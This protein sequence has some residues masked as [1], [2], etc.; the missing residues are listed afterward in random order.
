[1]KNNNLIIDSNLK[2]YIESVSIK[3]NRDRYTISDGIPGLLLVLAQFYVTEKNIKSKEGI[4]SLAWDYINQAAQQNISLS[5]SN[6]GLWTGPLGL[7]VAA[8]TWSRIAD[9]SM[10]DWNLI[11]RLYYQSMVFLIKKWSQISRGDLENKFKRDIIFGFPGVLNYICNCSI[12]RK[13]EENNP[14]FIQTLKRIST[15]SLLQFYVKSSSSI[16]PTNLGM[17]HGLSGLLIAILQYYFTFKSLPKNVMQSLI[18]DSDYIANYANYLLSF[19]DNANYLFINN[20]CTGIPGLLNLMKITNHKRVFSKLSNYID[21]ESKSITS[22][23][24]MCLCHGYGS[25]ALANYVFNKKSCDLPV[26]SDYYFSV[27]KFD[28]Y[29]ILSGPGGILALS[30]SMQ[31]SSPFLLNWLFGINDF[32]KDYNFRY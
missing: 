23:N 24:N 5:L 27:H 20:W 9:N 28:S 31:K 32:S 6:Q 19:T 3:N 2:K 25:I 26:F 1:M 14:L 29:G 18:L 4:E 22:E 15:K 21:C 12:A 17:A 7:S 13:S 11:N 16:N 30:R 8:D 10:Y